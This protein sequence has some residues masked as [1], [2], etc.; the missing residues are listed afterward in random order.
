[1][2]RPNDRRRSATHPHAQMLE[3]RRERL[4]ARWLGPVASMPIDGPVLTRAEY[5]AGRAA[6]ATEGRLAG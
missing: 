1:M 5:D 4:H 6:A 3:R 2:N